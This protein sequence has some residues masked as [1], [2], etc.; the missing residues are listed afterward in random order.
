MKVGLVAMSGI[1]VCDQELLRL[2]LT[3]PGFVERSRT[4]AS[5]PSLGLLTLAALTRDRHEVSY[6]EVPDLAAVDGLPGDFDLV[7]IS[8]YSAQVDEAYALARRY[9]QHGVPVVMGGPHCTAEPDEALESCDAVVVGEG[10]PAWPLVLADAARG[11]LASRYGSRSSDY[12]LASSPLPAFDLLDVG[13][14]NRLTVQTSRGCPHRCQFCASSVLL[15]GRYKQKPAERVLA[16][17]DA[18]LGLWPRPFLELADDNSLVDRAYWKGLLPELVGRGVRWFAETDLSVADDPEL[19]ELMRQSG[20]AQV[21]VGLESPTAGP[22]AG[23]E[24]R[25]DWKRRRFPGYR[26]AIQTI[27]DHG[28]TVNGCFVLGLDGQGPEV[29][30]QVLAFVR[31]T[32]LFEVQITILTPFPGTPLYD[33]LA[34]EGRLLAPRDWRRCTL[35]DLNFRPQGMPGDELVERFRRLGAELYGDEMTRWRRERF[36]ERVR[37]RLLREE[38]GR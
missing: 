36:K 28:I 38:E 6:L 9:R 26:R 21:L 20:C 22:L 10:E 16:E 3:L 15:T 4:I 19:L 7:G 8:T 2:G 34:G 24:L 11:A 35:F 31:S 30:D 1:R 32:E 23:V 14:Y 5:L 29:F 18:I 25:S 27:Q 37:S 17:V 12:D 13:R 33:R